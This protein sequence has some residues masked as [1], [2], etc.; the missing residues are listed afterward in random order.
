MDGLTLQ[1]TPSDVLGPSR[2]GRKIVILGDTYDSSSIIPIAKDAD[3]LVHE[4]T[5]ENS[6]EE[7]C[8][9]NGHST[10]SKFQPRIA[11][12]LLFIMHLTKVC[13]LF[14]I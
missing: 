2:P 14:I 6:H 7:R 4:A 1:I 10:P 8:I 11:L 13:G 12:L 5:N 9:E 3:L